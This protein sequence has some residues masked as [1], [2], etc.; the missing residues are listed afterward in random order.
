MFDFFK[1]VYAE[2]NGLDYD[3]IKKE[4]QLKKEQKADGKI[5]NTS[6]K[7]IIYVMGILYLIVGSVSISLSL[8]SGFNLIIFKYILLIILDI[9]AIILISIKNKNTQLIGLICI[10]LFMIINF[11][12]SITGIH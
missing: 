12:F 5:I 11:T 6:T 2:M 7:I 9:V 1:D 10:G 4:K 3:I 8:R